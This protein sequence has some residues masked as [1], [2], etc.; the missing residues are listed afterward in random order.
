MALPTGTVTF[1]RSDIEGSMALVRALGARYDGANAEHAAIVR[2]AV[3]AHAGQVV[4]TEGDAFF[5]VFT[6]AGAAARA[7]IEVQR[8]MAA[9]DWPEGHP[10]RLRIGLHTGVATRAGDD[11]GGFEVNRAARIAAA[12]RG[13]QVICSGTARALIAADPPEGAEL[14]DLGWHRLKGIPEPERLFQLAAPGLERDFGPLRTGQGP[15]EHLPERTATFV[16]RERE[17][18]ELGRLLARSRLITLLG[19][20]GT[21][22]TTLAVELARRHAG[23]HA[24]GA[25]FVDLAGVVDPEPAR[26]QAAHD[27]GLFDGPAGPAVDRLASYLGDRDLLI[28]V[29][30]LEQ[31]RAGD[32]LVGELLRSSR[33]SRIIATS[34]TPLHLTVE[35]AFPLRPLDLDGGDQEQSEA[36]RLFVE[37][38]RRVHPDLRVGAADG[39]AIESIC[40]LVDGLPLAIELCAARAAVL[41]VERIEERLRRHLPLPGSGPRDLPA[42][43][44]TLEDTVAWSLELLDPPLQELFTR[45]GVFESSFELEQA[46]AVCATDDATD[47]LDGLVRLAEQSL[48]VRLDDAV[49]GVRFDML[50]T[51]RAVSRSRLQTTDEIDGLRFRHARAYLAL[52]ERFM[53]KHAEPT[54]ATWLARLDA[55]DDNL[56]DAVHWAIETGQVKLAHGLVGYLWRYWVHSGRLVLGRE[57]AHA[58]LTMA[59]ADAPTE[60]RAWA[61]SA[62]GSLDYW[63]N[64]IEG[65]TARYEAQLALA[66]EV[67]SALAEADAWYNLMFVRRIFGDPVGAEEAGANTLRILGQLGEDRLIGD[68]AAHRLLIEAPMALADPTLLTDLERRAAE[69]ARTEVAGSTPLI[70]QGALPNIR[71]IACL[72]AGDIPGAA[73]HLAG[74][75]RTGLTWGRFGDVITA[76]GFI[77]AVGARHLDAT[78]I[79]TVQGALE[80]AVERY[81]V[82]GPPWPRQLAPLV[83]EDPLAGVSD[84]LGRERFE[85]ARDEGRHMTLEQIVG[86]IEELSGADLD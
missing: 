3:A 46:E 9:H 27:L 8:E 24:D 78:A 76:L 13:G 14:L 32:E 36:V 68:L 54:D 58:A 33:S 45:L 28:V 5:V 26:A 82:S 44:Q 16:G 60:A 19:P 37:R 71:A 42:R 4:R 10:L 63:S 17:L 67:G 74:A 69:L 86:F 29:D 21:G 57:L 84:T 35:Q 85:R 12:G 20:G 80:A 70:A 23:E 65:A 31:L 22:K 56:R 38:A 52:A 30:N 18:A 43:Q 49:G 62:A 75:L 41:P 48:L 2:V 51:I 39:K 72:A 53:A 59:G 83:P 79:A 1:L 15:D 66:L 40:R 77:V 81:G 11:Y 55:D 25:W 64:D 7:A 6:D 61:L 73:R 47:V 50:E 34:R